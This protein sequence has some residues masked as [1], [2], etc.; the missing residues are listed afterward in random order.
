MEFRFYSNKELQPM[1]FSFVMDLKF[2]IIY[3]TCSRFGTHLFTFTLF[4]KATKDN[5]Q[6]VSLDVWFRSLLMRSYLLLLEESEQ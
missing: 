2:C 1:R 3:K 4:S 5:F 6:L